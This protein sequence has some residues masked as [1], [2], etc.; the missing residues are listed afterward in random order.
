ME[1]LIKMNDLGVR[2]FSETP[3][4]IHKRPG[5]ISSHMVF[6]GESSCGAV[7]DGLH[8]HV[9]CHSQAA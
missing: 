6:A 4:Y 2:L 8:H 1:N 3:M 9:V 7:S 5:R